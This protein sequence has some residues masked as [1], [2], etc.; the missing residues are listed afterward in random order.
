MKKYQKFFKQGQEITISSNEI[1]IGRFRYFLTEIQESRI[2]SF[3]PKPKIYSMLIMIG[4]LTWGYLISNN[5][6]GSALI[7]IFIFPYLGRTFKPAKR[8][9]LIIKA[10][11]KNTIPAQS[12]HEEDLLPILDQIKQAIE[13]QEYNQN[14]NKIKDEGNETSNYQPAGT[15][16][17]FSRTIPTNC[18]KCNH[19]LV[20]EQIIWENIHH[21]KCP[22]CQ[23]TIAATWVKQD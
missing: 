7:L 13:A 21:G 11:N 9:Q 6:L 15:N 18:A 3:T 17:N 20:I 2:E 8:F 1:I 23:H 10:N 16:A 22:N 19:L 12:F 14:E 4:L 5:I